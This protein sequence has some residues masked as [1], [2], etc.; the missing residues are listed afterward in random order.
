MFF[1][2]YTAFYAGSVIY[3]VDW[4]FML[5]L[6]A[7]VAMFGGFAAAEVLDLVDYYAKKV[8]KK[9]TAIVNGIALIVMLALIFTPIYLMMP[10]LA[11]NPSNIQQAGDARFDENF[12][13]NSS[14]LIPSNCI[15]YSY[16][17]TLFQLNNRTSRQIGDLYNTSQV[18]QYMQQQKCLV[19]DYGYWCYTPQNQCTYA[20]QNYNI[21]PLATATYNAMGRT[22]G[23]YYV[24]PQQR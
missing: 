2:L 24:Y 6:V 19:L 18:D 1:L 5:S 23:F 21:V 13:Y 16:D 20:S 15:V 17:P 22:Y 12:V 3:G 11:V 10:L 8:M 9:R 14:S 4:R 7:Q